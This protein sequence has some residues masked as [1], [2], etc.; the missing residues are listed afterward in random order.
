MISAYALESMVVRVP[1][2][3]VHDSLVPLLQGW[4]RTTLQQDS[5]GCFFL[6]VFDCFMTRETEAQDPAAYLEVRRHIEEALRSAEKR[7]NSAH[8]AMYRWMANQFN[9]H[10]TELKRI[11]GRAPARL[12]SMSDVPFIETTR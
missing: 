9:S 8:V 4:E 12:S 11:A 5:D 2:I 3:V 1:R 7:A 6:N 10:I